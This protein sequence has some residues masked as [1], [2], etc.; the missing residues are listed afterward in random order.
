MLAPLPVTSQEDEPDRIET[1]RRAVRHV[2]KE[3][4]FVRL[5]PEEKRQLTEIAYTYKSQ[6]LKTSEN[7]ISRIGINWMLEDYH[8]NGQQSVLAQVLAALDA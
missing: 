3:V 7:E 2:G 6:G 4:S 5:T 1:I 8:A